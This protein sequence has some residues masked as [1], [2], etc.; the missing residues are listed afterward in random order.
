MN[1]T[2]KW[3]FY[4]DNK[5]VL[6]E[7]PLN[8]DVEYYTKLKKLLKVHRL[9]DYLLVRVGGSEHVDG[10]YLM[11][12]S[13][14]KNQVAYSFGINNDVSWDSAMVDKGYEVFMY[15]HTIS[16]LPYE[17]AGFNFFV[18]GIA[19]KPSLDGK[20]DTLENYIK[21]NGHNGKRGMILKMDVEGAEWDFLETVP[22]KVLKQ[23]DQIVFE[24]H[25]LVRAC[26]KEEMERRLNC[27]H[28]LNLTHQLVHLHA[29][30]TGYVLQMKG[31]TL[32]DVLE[33]TY[34]NKERF[35]TFEPQNLDLPTPDDV[36]CDKNREDINLSTWNIPFEEDPL[37]V[38]F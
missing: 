33:V 17:K 36:P 11:A 23:F 31:H 28:K 15:D 18:Q 24:F 6:I 7:A 12:K 10:H 32:P 8:T 19:G 21:R 1:I 25:N 34:V 27:L 30:N 26:S 3:G 2:Y 14:K 9:K 13:F 22:S 37:S 38:Q 29:N 4:I 16:T 5:L 20:M 35:E